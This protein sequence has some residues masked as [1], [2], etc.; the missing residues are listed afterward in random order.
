MQLQKSLA[1][2]WRAQ[3][4]WESVDKDGETRCIVYVNAHVR[5]TKVGS[6]AQAVK[7]LRSQGILVTL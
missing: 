2:S 1:T 6:P 4:D 7:L 5:A 3:G